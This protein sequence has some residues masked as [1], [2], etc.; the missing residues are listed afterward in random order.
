MK[1]RFA[2]ADFAFPLLSHGHSLG[3][4][5]MLGFQG[6]DIGLFE[7]RS[8]LHPSR[9][10]AAPRRSA[11]RLRRELA[12]RGL[13]AA[14]VFLQMAPDFT[15][16]AINHPQASRRAKA[17]DWFLRSLD[18]ADALG[19]GHVTTLPGVVFEAGGRAASLDRSVEELSWRVAKSREAGIVF[20]TEAHVGS[21]APTPEAA[22]RLVGRTPGLTLTLDYTHF[23]RAGIPDRRVE[24]LVRHAS[25]FHAR[26]ARRG[27]LQCNLSENAIDYPRLVR[28]MKA[29]GY[30]GWIGVEYI[31]IDWERCNQSD[32]VSE[33]ILLRDL[34]AR[35]ASKS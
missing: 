20:G 17:R 12:S 21:I 3:L 8:H 10:F 27:R 15:P 31:W 29:S 9:E 2:C 32:N 24:P 26:C 28:A 30:R 33:T 18:Y 5:S 4:I 34:I 35:A 7:G 16:Y 14:D 22:A 23:T 11:A 19:C 13:V 6:V 1:T 25:H